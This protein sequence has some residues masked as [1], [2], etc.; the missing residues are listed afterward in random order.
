MFG[1]K[2]SKANLGSKSLK[3]GLT[4]LDTNEIKKRS[5]SALPNRDA[6]GFLY[7]AILV[8]VRQKKNGNIEEAIPDVYPVTTQEISSMENFLVKAE[9][10]NN[11]TKVNDSYFNDALKEL[12]K[13]VKWSGKRHWN[14]QWAIILGVLVSVMLLYW[15][16]GSNSKDTA[17]AGQLVSRVENWVACDTVVTNMKAASFPAHLN[18]YDNAT[19]YK[20]SLLAQ[21]ATDYKKASLGVEDLKFRLDTASSVAVRDEIQKSIDKAEKENAKLYEKFK[22]LNTKTYDEIKAMALKS[23]NSQVRSSRIS[24]GLIVTLAIIFIVLIPVYMFAERPYGYALSKRRKKLESMNIFQKKIMGFFHAFTSG[25][26]TLELLPEKVIKRG[27]G[28]ARKELNLKNVLVLIFRF[29]LLI[30]TLAL[31]CIL[32]CLLIIYKTVA[33]LRSNYSGSK[34][35]VAE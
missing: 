9:E 4:N 24:G 32:S 17:A 28:D 5:E 33:G 19:L 11:R 8:P 31:I 6:Y 1:K 22:E 16:S 2:K 21:V 14:F 18:A 7:E 12:R 35:A 3:A 27:E 20:A 25:T 13:I 23:A 34:K 15:W 30:I 29:I 26:I 10:E